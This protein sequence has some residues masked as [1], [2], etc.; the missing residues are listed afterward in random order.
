[1]ST[2]FELHD[3]RAYSS[4][5]LTVKQAIERPMIGEVTPLIVANN[6]FPFV[7]TKMPRSVTEASCS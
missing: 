1:M 4:S 5:P 3:Y 2:L 6:H 7:A